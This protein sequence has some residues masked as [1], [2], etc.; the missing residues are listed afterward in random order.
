MKNHLGSNGN[1]CLG[2]PW[3]VVQFSSITDWVVGGTWWMIVRLTRRWDPNSN[4]G[5]GEIRWGGGRGRGAFD[6][7]NKKTWPVSRGSCLGKCSLLHFVCFDLF[8]FF[9]CLQNAGSQLCFR[10]FLSYQIDYFISVQFHCQ[11]K[12]RVQWGGL[13]AEGASSR[14]SDAQ[15]SGEGHS[16]R[17]TLRC[18]VFQIHSKTKQN[19][20]SAVPNWLSLPAVLFHDA[21]SAGVHGERWTWRTWQQERDQVFSEVIW[22]TYVIYPG[23]GW[24]VGMKSPRSTVPYLLVVFTDFHS[25][26]VLNQKIRSGS[27]FW[28]LVSIWRK[29]HLFRR[30]HRC[31]SFPAYRLSFPSLF[32]NTRSV[33]VNECLQANPR[34]PQANK[35]NN[36]NNN[37]NGWF[38][39]S[40]NL[41]VKKTHCAITH[42]S[43][44][45]THKHKHNLP[46]PTH[47]HTHTRHGSLR[48]VEMPVEKIKFWA[49][50]WSQRG[51][52]DS[53]SWQATNSRQLEQWNWKNGRQQITL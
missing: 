37:D 7:N 33:C 5:S 35:H 30:L 31:P 11:L 28:C 50:F 40:A 4:Y 34:R 13:S 29:R 12:H 45:Y 15:T 19:R 6:N 16:R 20:L 38:L 26:Y 51:W 36:N 1:G 32:W 39:Y 53:A 48:F 52:G 47:T 49:G 24:V 3:A 44:K 23:V 8:S 41:P 18:C 27:P 9:L 46:I 17:Q 14:V 22:A 10:F 2:W 25:I 21:Q 43:R 42:H